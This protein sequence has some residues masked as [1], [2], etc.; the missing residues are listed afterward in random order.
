MS[1]KLTDLA[2]A[3]FAVV[4]VETTGLHAGA[5]DRILEVAIVHT[6]TPSEAR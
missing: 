6:W 4:D 3:P 5:R 2:S 1:R